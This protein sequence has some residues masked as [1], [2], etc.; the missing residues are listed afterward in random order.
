MPTEIVQLRGL[1]G[2]NLY[3]PQ[4]GVFLQVRSTTQRARRLKD[5]LKDGAQ[6]IGMVLGHLEVDTF[7]D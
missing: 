6:S 4:P 3:M 5:A 2:P 7:V 1:E